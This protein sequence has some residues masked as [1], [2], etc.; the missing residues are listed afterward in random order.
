MCKVKTET[1]V[2]EKMNKLRLEEEDFVICTLKEADSFDDVYEIGR[3][4]A[5]FPY[6][7]ISINTVLA[8][9]LGAEEVTT[10][11]VDD[12]ELV[13]EAKSSLV[14]NVKY[15]THYINKFRPSVSKIITEELLVAV[16]GVPRVTYNSLDEEK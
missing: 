5:S 13:E 11:E 3:V 16:Y 8:K 4:L 7:D 2:E 6:T 14:F 1:M 12:I 9:V 10:E 15:K